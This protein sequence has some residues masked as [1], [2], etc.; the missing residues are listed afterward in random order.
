[1]PT[2]CLYR[3]F[4]LGDLSKTLALLPSFLDRAYFPSLLI[5]SR[6]IEYDAGPTSMVDLLAISDNLDPGLILKLVW[7]LWLEVA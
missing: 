1:M 2:M 4:G 6:L 7:F 5:S 3:R